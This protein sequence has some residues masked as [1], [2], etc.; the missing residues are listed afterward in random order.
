MRLVVGLGNPGSSYEGSRHNVG[1]RVIDLLARRSGITTKE[2][3][4]RALLGYGKIGGQ[5]VI[6][7]KPL[8]YMN[9]SGYAVKAIM[10]WHSL[11]TSQLLVVYDD[12]DLDLGRIRIRPRGSAGGHNGMKSIITLVGS[13]DFPRVRVGIGKPSPSLDSVEHVLG[14][15]SAEEMPVISTAIEWAANAVELCIQEGLDE[16]MNRYNGLVID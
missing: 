4:F 1:F 7:A 14:W 2:R 11:E 16:A 10:D 12:M 13:E 5:D 3:R 9:L 8:T 6:L 15:F